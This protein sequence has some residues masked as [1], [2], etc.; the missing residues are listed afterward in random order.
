MTCLCG[1]E[2]DDYIHQNI[3]LLPV[4]QSISY[5][6]RHLSEHQIMCD[7]RFERLIGSGDQQ[8]FTLIIKPSWVLAVSDERQSLRQR[9]CA[10]VMAGLREQ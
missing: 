6:R 3:L 5:V 8:P 10:V 4:V 9:T 2:Q 7:S 1:Y